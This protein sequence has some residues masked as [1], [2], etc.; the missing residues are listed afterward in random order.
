[1]TS[2]FFLSVK[3]DVNVLKSNKKKLF[4]L[5][6]WRPIMKRAGSGAGAGSG[7]VS[8]RYGSEDADPYQ[9]V[10]DPGHW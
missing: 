2:L 5:A 10:T 4:K 1:V 6:S 7:S 9:N 8:Q 3:N